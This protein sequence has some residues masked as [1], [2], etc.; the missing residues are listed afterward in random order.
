MNN[1]DES[2]SEMLVEMDK[3]HAEYQ[4]LYRKIYAKVDI[5]A[6]RIYDIKVSLC[7]ELR[8]RILEKESG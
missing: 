8:R 6:K 1:W 3:E 2:I 4:R 7:H 5:E